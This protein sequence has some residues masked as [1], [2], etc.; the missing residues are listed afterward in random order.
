MLWL[1]ALWGHNVGALKF[2]IFVITLFAGADVRADCTRL[3]FVPIMPDGPGL[4]NQCHDNL[5]RHHCLLQEGFSH[6]KS[7]KTSDGKNAYSIKRANPGRTAMKKYIHSLEFSPAIKEVN[8][9]RILARQFARHDQACEPNY[10]YIGSKPVFG[11]GPAYVSSTRFVVD[12]RTTTNLIVAEDAAAPYHIPIKVLSKDSLLKNHYYDIVIAHELAHGIMQ[13]LYG[14]DRFTKLEAQ[15]ISR[16]GHFASAI[17][18]PTLAWIEGFAE[19]FE[20]YLGEKYMTEAQQ[21]TPVLDHIAATAQDRLAVFERSGWSGYLF[22]VPGTILET[23]KT[24]GHLDDFVSDFLKAERQQTIRENHYVLKGAFNNLAHRYNIIS[25]RL[26]AYDLEA[27]SDSE[28]ESTEAV[29][30]KEGVVAHFIYQALKHGFSREVFKTIVLGRPNDFREFASLF[31]V[32]LSKDQLEVMAP[33]YK[34]IFTRK[35]RRVIRGMILNPESHASFEKHLNSLPVPHALAHPKNWFIE[36]ANTSML[37]Q[38]LNGHM[39][40][41]N[42]AT[43]SAARLEDALKTLK[44]SDAD[45]TRVLNS[46]LELRDA[47]LE[48]NVSLDQMLSTWKKT[49]SNLHVHETAKQLTAFRRC[50]EYGCLSSNRNFAE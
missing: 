7:A 44:Y 8:S 31:S 11:V 12:G 35:G 24:L 13:D 46:L 20:A 41:I 26:P 28:I 14:V 30:S 45:R 47:H 34:T 22:T 6:F 50:F 2:V 40:R 4:K 5:D 21:K 42:V 32:I 9:L 19:G 38:K 25:W 29:Y 15:V 39:D 27:L 10:I 49:N 3:E 23:F 16:D 33:V 43:A 17:T 1:V 36:F 37:Q 48:K 18:D